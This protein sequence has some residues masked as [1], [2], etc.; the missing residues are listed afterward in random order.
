MKWVD[1]EGLSEEISAKA[2]TLSGVLSGEPA[3][4]YSVATPG[5]PPPEE[6]QVRP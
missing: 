4:A 5:A 6:G 2:T 3:K 1:L